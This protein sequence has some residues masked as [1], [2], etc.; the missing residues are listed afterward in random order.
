MARSGRIMAIRLLA[1]T[2]KG[3]AAFLAA[4]VLVGAVL[5]N[6]TL[7]AMGVVV[8]RVPAAAHGG[9]SSPAG[10]RLIESVVVAGLLFLGTLLLGPVQV[11]L[12][13]VLRVRL[14]YRM[15]ARLMAAVSGP[16]GIAHLEDQEVLD[17]LTR[18][19]GSLLSYFP[20]DAP[21]M[22]GLVVST[23]CS[24][25]I[26]CGVLASFRWWLGLAILLAWLAA[27]RPMWQELLKQVGSLRANS[28]TGRRALYFLDLATRAPAAKEIRV[29]GLGSWVIERFHSLSIE[30]MQEAW[31]RLVRLNRII[32]AVS[33]L[34]ILVYVGACLELGFA[35]SHGEISLQFL[36]VLLLM[37][38]MSTSV[39]GITFA[40]IGLEY[41][42]S[43]LPDL[44]ELER[45]LSRSVDSL[46]GT[47]TARGLPR[48][49]VHFDDVSFTYAGSEREILQHLDLTLPSGR[50][51]AVVGLN[52]AGK[53]TLVKLLARLHDP[54]SGRILVDG[55]ALA[56]LEPSE[57][58]R[59]VAV[60]FQDFNRYPL[61]FEENVGLGSHESMDDTA[62]ILEASNRA[63]A[64]SIL[65]Q[66]PGG[67]ETVL[68]PQY[69]GGQDLSG[70]QWQRIAL[71][72]AL[73]AVRHGARILVLDEPTAWLDARGEAEFF[74]RFLDITAG[75]TTLVI[76]H[77]FSTVRRADHICVLAD[78]HIAEQ[79]AH[80]E[81]VA[82]GGRYATMFNLQA[83]RFAADEA[84]EDG[85]R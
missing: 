50:S 20:A 72:R 64:S 3:W 2:S 45:R 46:A 18:A 51:T 23:R 26:A 8:G 58:Q 43:S 5:P 52:G 10:H 73:F 82:G 1:E 77:R 59:Q 44:D 16:V 54:S 48:T 15:Q 57:W 69:G 14:T 56:E 25:L 34:I 22:L 84:S 21:L 32:W 36:T 27:R 71:A 38:V 79:G 28:E 9:L 40:D 67:L 13:A 55:T 6:L 66:L 85:S 78:G 83:A 65:D 12:S 63:G 61:S 80:E 24:G 68:S 53:T 42:V 41:M 31:Q 75:V 37:L 70:G 60:V 19:Q 4:W 29:F 81:L 11:A 47:R 30:T 49:Q 39:G 62:G 7:V 76:S 74:D 35:A 17:L 33:G